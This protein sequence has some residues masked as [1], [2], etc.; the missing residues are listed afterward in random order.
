MEKKKFMYAITYRPDIEIFLKGRG[1]EHS[2]SDADIVVIKLDAFDDDA[3]AE[4]MIDYWRW[5]GIRDLELAS[6]KGER[7]RKYINGE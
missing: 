5:S 7:D 3:F 6:W 4:L 1:V 2:I